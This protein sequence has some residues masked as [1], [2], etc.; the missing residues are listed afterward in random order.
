MT[1]ASL[2]ILTFRRRGAPGRTPADEVDRA[3]RARSS[4]TLAAAGDVLLTSTVIGGRYAIRLCILNHTSAEA[5]VEYALERVATADSRP[6]RHR[7]DA[8]AA[9]GSLQAGVALEWLDRAGCRRGLAPPDAAVFGCIADEQAERFLGAAREETYAA[10][11]AV[12]ERWTLARTFYVVLRGRLAV[13]VDGHEVNAL[14]PGDHLGEI[15]AIDWG[16]DFSYGRTATVVATEDATLLAFPA[17]A[18]R[19]LMTDVPDI[20]RA[21]RRIAQARL[22]TR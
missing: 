19:E 2:G 21:V 7:A 11:E 1:P 20:D 22:T 3:Q 15:A 6:R 4:P 12:T 8:A 18:L 16:R 9:R 13:R 14:G 17:A 10:G 5:D